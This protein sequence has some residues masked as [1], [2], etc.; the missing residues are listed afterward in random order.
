MDFR[1]HRLETYNIM[2]YRYD[3]YTNKDLKLGFQ[4][5]LYYIRL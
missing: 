2:A 5:S 3:T 1:F 4:T